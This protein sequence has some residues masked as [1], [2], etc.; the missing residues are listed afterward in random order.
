M[1]KKIVTV[2]GSID[3]EFIGTTLPHE[4]LLIDCRNWMVPP[5]NDPLLQR[6]AKK[7]VDVINRGE[8]IYNVC[9]IEDNLY[10]LD[11]KVAIDEVKKFKIA[12]GNTIVDVTLETIGRDPN[13]LIE[14]SKA[15]GVNVIMGS[16][17]YVES[18]WTQEDKRRSIKNL[19]KLIINEFQNGICETRIKPGIIGEI[20][21]SDIN[22]GIE[23]K[24]LKAAALAQKEINCALSIH[25]PNWKK[26]GHKILDILQEEGVNLN[27]VVLSHCD[28]TLHD[29]DYNDALAKRGAY[30]EY[31]Q[32][33]VEHMTVENKFSPSDG[34]K[35]KAVY[36]QII[37]GNIDKILISHDIATK[38]EWTKWGGFGHSHILKHIKPRMLD[39]GITKEQ[40]DMIMIE[41][42]KR[43]LAF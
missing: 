41:N 24:G 6:I 21:I 18:A 38:M 13:A 32:F 28:F 35:I 25:M 42:P 11:V 2:L 3:P 4:H 8:I 37:K 36:D 15:T 9:S 12:G 20:G 22:N 7:P 1:T 10:Q 17:Y 5:P 30:I 26:E 39:M 27:K 29:S 43:M 23:I 40:I 14:I 31:D 19:A 33:G 34:E 16:G